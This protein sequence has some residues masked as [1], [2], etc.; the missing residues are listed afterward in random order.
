MA[1]KIIVLVL[2][3]ALLIACISGIID[4]HVNVDKI[5]DVKNGIL[6]GF[7]NNNDIIEFPMS[8]KE[9]VWNYARASIP[10]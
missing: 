1:G 9:I 5:E 2:V 6:K 8:N 7:T 3:I 4:V 10:R